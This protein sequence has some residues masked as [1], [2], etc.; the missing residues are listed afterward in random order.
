[1]SQYSA[2]V[3]PVS[4]RTLANVERRASI[5][6]GVAM[7]ALSRP[8]DGQ[9]AI[10]WGATVRDLSSSGIG[11]SLCYPFRPG[12]Y[13]AIDLQSSAGQYRTLL[14]RVVQARDQADGTWHIGCEFVKQLTDS[15]VELMI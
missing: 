7:E 14:T 12:T 9:D 6:H 3:Q 13:L 10:W 15:D 11:L 5:R 2:L 4:A 1:M 8:L